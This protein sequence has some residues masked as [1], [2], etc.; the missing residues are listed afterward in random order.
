[1]PINLAPQIAGSRGALGTG[2]IVAIEDDDVLRSVMAEILVDEGYEVVVHGRTEGAHQ[3]V[4]QA[5]PAV[6]LMDLRL[7]DGRAE[8]GWDLLDQLVLDPATRNIPVVIVSGDPS[9]EMHRLALSADHGVWTLPKPFEL[10]DLLDVVSRAA[11]SNAQC[12]A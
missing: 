5:Q 10:V 1:V 12:S 9:L 8:R 4:R 6:V 7:G 11:A 3:L 2:R